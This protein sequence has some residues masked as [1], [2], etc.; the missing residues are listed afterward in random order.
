[1]GIHCNFGRYFAPFSKNAILCP[2]IGAGAAPDMN[3]IAFLHIAQE[4]FWWLITALVAYM[5]IAPVYDL[6]LAYPFL[7]AN[8]VYVA[9]FLTLTRYVFLLKYSFFARFLPF[10]LFLLFGSLP[11]LVYLISLMFQF[12]VYMNEEGTDGFLRL[13]RDLDTPLEEVQTLYAYFRREMIFFG[14]GSIIIT[15]ITPFRML[16]SAWRVYHNTG[17]V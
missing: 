16:I 8:I 5:V 1:M 10:K 4:L 9:V 7:S 15:V 14:T 6:L 11:L 2:A 12:Q 13:L 17:R 3:K